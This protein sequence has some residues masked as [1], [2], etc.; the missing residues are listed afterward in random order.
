MAQRPSR[1][2]QS[3]TVLAVPPLITRMLRG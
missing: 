1:P 2:G 3:C